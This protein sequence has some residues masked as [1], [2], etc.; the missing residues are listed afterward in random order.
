M[1]N[2]LALRALRKAGLTDCT[3]SFELKASEI[4]ALGAE[5]DFGV[6]GYGRLPMMLTANCPIAAQ[7]GCKGCTGAVYD[8]TGRRMPVKCS[9]GQ[10]YVEILNSDILHIGDRLGDFPSAKFVSLAF[11]EED[12]RKV[13]E[14]AEAFRKGI[15]P[16]GEGFTKGL[17]FR[18]VK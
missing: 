3:V 13:R 8:R 11:Y 16:E 12:P 17:Y 7:R 14:T 1:T 10:G 18:G 6:L 5:L 9:R 4:A 15:R 2:T